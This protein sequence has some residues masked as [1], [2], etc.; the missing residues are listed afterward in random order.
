MIFYYD[1]ISVKKGIDTI[2]YEHNDSFINET[3]STDVMAVT[4]FFIIE[5]ILTIRNGPVIDVTKS[6]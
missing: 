3:I 4:L 2:T 1:R 6:Y 5:E